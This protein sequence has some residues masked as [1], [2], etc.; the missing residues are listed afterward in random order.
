VLARR[1]E[2]RLSKAS[3][4]KAVD[5]YLAKLPPDR[6]TVLRAVRAQIRAVAPDAVETLSYGIPTYKVDGKPLAYFAAFK[7]HLSLFAL[8]TEELPASARRHLAAKGTI[9]FTPE[10]PLPEPVL[11]KL[12]KSRLAAIRGGKALR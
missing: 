5:E 3:S 11:R 12:L 6:R 4:A 2:L 7:A 1:A 10:D 9:Q 8:P